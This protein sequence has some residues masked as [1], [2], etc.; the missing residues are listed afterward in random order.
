[1][2]FLRLRGRFEEECAEGLTEKVTIAQ[3]KE[4]FRGQDC[5]FF[6]GSAG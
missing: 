2:W 6:L 4:R 1:M 5:N 3:A